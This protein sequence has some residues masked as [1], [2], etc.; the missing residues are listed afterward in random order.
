L[1]KGCIK[2]VQV[3]CLLDYPEMEELESVLRGQIEGGIPE[4]LVAMTMQMTR[5]D[6]EQEQHPDLWDWDVKPTDLSSNDLAPPEY[7]EKLKGIALRKYHRHPGV[8]S[9]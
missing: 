1:D 8:F 9:K 3:V 7:M 4:Q 6:E 5:E 2:K